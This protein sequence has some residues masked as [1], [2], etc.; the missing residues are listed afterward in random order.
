[1]TLNILHKDI[2]F[3]PGDKIKVIQNIKDGEK[4][5]SQV[6]EGL[7]I[8]IKGRNENKSFMVR[9][10]GAGQVGIERIFPLISP[11]I[12]KIEVIKKGTKGVR[13]AK[14]YYT[15]DKS[16]REVDLIYQRASRKESA[17]QEAI[18]PSKKR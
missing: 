4:V 3:G 17:S 15:R 1:M 12:E 13:R 11:T 14:L 8:G 16:R 6:F 18:K 2:S 9:R 7:V 10:I 5:R